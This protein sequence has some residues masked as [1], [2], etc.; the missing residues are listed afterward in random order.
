MRAAAAD[1]SRVEGGRLLEGEQ[2]P[3]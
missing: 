3:S 2:Q 1:V